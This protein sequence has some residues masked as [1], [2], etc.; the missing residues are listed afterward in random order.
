VGAGLGLR[1]VARALLDVVPV[2]G[3]AVKSAIAYSGTR[4]LGN[5]AVWRLGNEVEAERSP[6]GHDES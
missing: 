1:T 6:G 2:G 3:W 5:A 4:A